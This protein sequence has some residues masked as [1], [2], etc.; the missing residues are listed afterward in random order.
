MQNFSDRLIAAI[1]AK[2]TAACV[3]L[4]PV[5]SKL[6][7]AIRAK[8]R[9][10]DSDSAIAAIAE[11]AQAIIEIV[12]PLVPIVKINSAYFEAYQS[13]GAA[14]Y[15]DLIGYAKRCADLVVIGDVKRGDI[16]HTAEMYACGHL[17]D[18]Q[19]ETKGEFNPDAITI[20]GYFGEDGVKPFVDAAARHGRGVFILV[21]TS[22]PSA[23]SVQDVAVSDGRKLHEL[24]AA[25]VEQWSRH[26]GMLGEGG[27]SSVGAVV[28]T[29]TPSDAARLRALMPRCF[30]LVPGYGA[31]G[32]TAE[33]FRPYFNRDGSGAIVAA[34]RSVIFAHERPEYE[35]LPWE[36]AIEAACKD[37]VTDLLRAYP[38]D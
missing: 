17:G 26:P 18:P 11:Y 7:T 19:G 36:K 27:Y 15:Q 9:P 37:F 32:G 31:Q 23:A 24:I 13:R 16:G 8:A 5:L 12:A 21:R 6:P 29:R 30:F 28:A 38:A 4:D 3:N 10:D 33:D 14:L 35:K 22:N 34:G 20:S 2:G 1:K 25:Q